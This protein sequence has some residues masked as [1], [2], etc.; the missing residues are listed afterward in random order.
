ML[1]KS[2]TQRSQDHDPVVAPKLHRVPL[3]SFW[4]GRRDSNP[5]GLLQRCLRPQRLPFRHARSQTDQTLGQTTNGPQGPSI[6]R[7]LE[8]KTGFE[9]ATFSLARRCSTTEPLPHA[10]GHPTSRAK[11]SHSVPLMSTHNRPRGVP[12]D[13]ARGVRP[14]FHGWSAVGL[15]ATISL[16]LGADGTDGGIMAGRGTAT[17]GGDGSGAP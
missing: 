10:T 13:F 6:H 4:C 16:G 7:I 15:P 14:R 17:G 12:Q 2:R 5:H 1:A 9:P 11:F 3:V 8:R